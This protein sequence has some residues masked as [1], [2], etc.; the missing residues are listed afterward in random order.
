[1]LDPSVAMDAYFRDIYAD[2]AQRMGYAVGMDV[3]EWQTTLRGA[4]LSLLA[5]T[6]TKTFEVHGEVLEEQQLDGYR[7][8]SVRF[9]GRDGVTIPAF[10]LIP[11]SLRRPGPAVICLH[12]HGPG[13]VVP[14]DYG[15]DTFGNPVVVEGERDF[16]VQAVREG[17]IAL[18]PDLRGFGEMM[19]SSEMTGEQGRNSC[20][21]MNMR[22]IMVGRTLLGMRVLD[23]M[24][25]VDF[26][27]QDPSIDPAR[28][29]MTGQSGGG[30]ATLFAAACDERIALAAPSCYFC[31][32]AHSIMA[33]NHCPCNYV[34][35]L[36]NLCEM[37]DIAGLIAPRPLLAIAGR[38][39]P[40]FPIEGVRYAYERLQTIYAA[41]GASDKLELYVGPEDHRYYKA[42]VWGFARENGT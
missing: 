25:T 6:P 1:V 8:Q 41:A 23:I 13:K 39:D 19:L 22:A 4:L 38:K 3:G 17:Y 10:K 31:T 36:L 28:V 20:L 26:L 15:K 30:T 11:D 14:V 33:M 40:I 18:A 12:G 9:I 37:Y 35:G 24:S 27:L 34:P 2:G 7:R 32:F 21:Q 29:M 5:V 16:A 42:R